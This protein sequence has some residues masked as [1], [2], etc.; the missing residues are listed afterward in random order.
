[1]NKGVNY[2]ITELVTLRVSGYFLYFLL[3]HDKF[4]MIDVQLG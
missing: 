1:M 3:K 2:L 4:C